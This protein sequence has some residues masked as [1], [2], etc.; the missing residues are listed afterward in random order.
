MYE[1]HVPSFNSM[2]L[3]SPSGSEQVRSDRDASVDVSLIHRHPVL[4]GEITDVVDV[5]VLGLKRAMVRYAQLLFTH[6]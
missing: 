1:L 2:P 4:P 3:F 6:I 5:V